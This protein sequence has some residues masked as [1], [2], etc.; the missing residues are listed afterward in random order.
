MLQAGG[1]VKYEE[2]LARAKTWAEARQKAKEKAD[3]DLARRMIA[4][5]YKALAKD[6]HPD[7]G[8]STDAMARLTGIR[9][10]LTET[11]RRPA[12]TARARELRAYRH[13]QHIALRVTVAILFVLGGTAVLFLLLMGFVV[14]E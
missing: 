4:A 3:R 1:A 5:G 14:P 7:K 6:L 12:M 8:G 13:T 11:V 10:Q 9:D 2:R